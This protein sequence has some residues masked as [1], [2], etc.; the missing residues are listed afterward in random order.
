LEDRIPWTVSLRWT[1]LSLFGLETQEDNSNP[2]LELYLT[3]RVGSSTW[4]QLRVRDE[5]EMAVGVGLNLPF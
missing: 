5:N 2:Q 1:P 4:H 3:N